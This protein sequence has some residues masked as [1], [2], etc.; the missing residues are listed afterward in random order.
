[1]E[2]VVSL[3]VAVVQTRTLPARTKVGYSGVHVTEGVTRLATIA[4]GYAD[5]LPRALSGRGAV[6]YRGIRLPIVGRV[7]MDSITIDVSALPEDALSLGNLVE[8][9]G[10]H[11][12]LEDIARDAGTISYEILTGLGHRYYR[13]YR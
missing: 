7:S 11:Q 13:H 3:E 6:Y 2:Q 1:M 12:S 5:G 9:I 10:P 8:V 4:A